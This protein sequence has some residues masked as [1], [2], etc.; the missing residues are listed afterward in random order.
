MSYEEVIRQ[1]HR[2]EAAVR[3][4]EGQIRGFLRECRKLD[5]EQL[6]LVMARLLDRIQLTNDPK[7]I[8]DAKFK[9]SLAKMVLDERLGG[10]EKPFGSFFKSVHW[11]ELPV[12]G[13]NYPCPLTESAIDDF[14]KKYSNGMRLLGD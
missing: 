11:S 2:F 5:R 4:F 8:L 12:W 10:Q 1:K 13:F 9:G 3:L 6:E 7:E 14:T